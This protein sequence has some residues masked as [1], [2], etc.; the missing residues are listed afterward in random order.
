VNGYN[1]SLLR[2]RLNSSIKVGNISI[3]RSQF[4]ELGSNFPMCKIY[5]YVITH[6][7]DK[8]YTI[9]DDNET[10]IADEGNEKSVNDIAE[11][12]DKSRGDLW[13]LYV[14]INKNNFD[15]YRN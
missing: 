14:R 13:S 10:F 1:N 5:E 11:L 15:T 7:V 3:D 4:S 8:T 9:T 6:N 2:C 12:F